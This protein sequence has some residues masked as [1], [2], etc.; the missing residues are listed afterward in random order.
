MLT[1]ALH[2]RVHQQVSVNS[3]LQ[4][5]LFSPLQQLRVLGNVPD[6]ERISRHMQSAFVIC[7][8]GT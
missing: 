2:T 8:L 4:M 5:Q 6:D 1:T 3:A 7:V